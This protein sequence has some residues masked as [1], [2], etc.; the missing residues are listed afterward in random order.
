LFYNLLKFKKMKKSLLLSAALMACGIMSAQWTAQATGFADASRGISQIRIVDANTVW[1]VAYDGTAAAAN[2]QE[3]TRTSDGG[4]TWTPGIIDVG[5]TA[6]EIINISPVSATTAWVSAIIGANGGGVIYK[7]TDGG[8]TWSQQNAAGYSDIAGGSFLDW[9]HFFDANNGLAVGDPINGEFE[10]YKTTD[11]GDTW[12]LVPASALPNPASG[13]YGYNGGN[14]A[15]GNSFWFVTNKG[16]I[17]RT[18]DMGT[19]WSKLNGPTGLTD[20]GAAAINGRLSFSDNLNGCIVG[21]LDTNA[22]TKFWTTSN[23]GLTWSAGVAYTGGYNKLLAYVPGTT[24]IVACGQ[25]ATAPAVPGSAFSSDNGVTWTQLDTGA[26]RGNVSFF[27]ATT[28]WCGGFSTDATTNGIFKYTGAAL[29]TT[30]FNATKN[31][32]V[33]SPNPTSG[34][35]K[36]IAA[37]S[38]INDV[39]VFDLL[40]KQVLA[41]KYN[42][43]NEVNVDMSNLQTGAYL[44]KATNAAG[45]TDTIKIMKN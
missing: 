4:T 15:A 2:V 24:T 14:V 39:A 42:A 38:T 21:T 40:G 12:T 9:V 28:G 43:L 3:F 31:Q 16:K 29:G 19:T 36:L 1:G 8:A 10:V 37:S 30:V 23:G 33:A 27:D 22:T 25:S 35:V 41:V 34:M 45:S 44:L 26:Q 20:F 13:E 11:G 32:I 6:Q 18:T 17:Y 7:T 5:D